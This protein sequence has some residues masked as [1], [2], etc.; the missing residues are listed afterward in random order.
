MINDKL[1]GLHPIWGAVVACNHRRQAPIREASKEYYHY[2]KRTGNI[3]NTFGD[4]LYFLPLLHRQYTCLD[5][6]N[7]AKRR[8]LLGKKTSELANGRGWSDGFVKIPFNN[9]QTE[10]TI[11]VLGR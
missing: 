5:A 6:G 11:P 2:Y 9:C 8:I 10:G 7:I 1:A 4:C 3:T